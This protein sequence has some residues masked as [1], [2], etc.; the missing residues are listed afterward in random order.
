MTKTIKNYLMLLKKEEALD[1][2]YSETYDNADRELRD[3]VRQ[4]IKDHEE[5]WEVMEYICENGLP[6]HLWEW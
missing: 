5:K 4:L 6:D 1:A 3:A 2:R